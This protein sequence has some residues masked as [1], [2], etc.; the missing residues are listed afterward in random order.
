MEL[1]LLCLVVV[2]AELQH[3][4]HQPLLHSTQPCQCHGASQN[5]QKQGCLLLKHSQSYSGMLVWMVLPNEHFSAS[6]ETLEG[7][8]G[9]ETL[10]S[11]C[12]TTLCHSLSLYLRALRFN[13]TSCIPVC[14]RVWLMEE[15]GNDPLNAHKSLFLCRAVGW[16]QAALQLPTVCPGCPCQRCPLG[17]LGRT[18]ELKL[19]KQ[20]QFWNY[21]I[22]GA[23]LSP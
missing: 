16:G 21:I 6:S 5:L 14:P 20:P 1:C 9:C 15:L 3:S 12:C 13:D 7:L 22:L 10:P 23:W 11:I 2:S 18:A 4:S 19:L 8:F 17:W